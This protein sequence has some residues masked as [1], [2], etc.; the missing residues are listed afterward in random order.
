MR[1]IVAAAV[2][3]DSRIRV[4]DLGC[5]TGALVARLAD[6]LPAATLVGLDVS[7][8]NIAAAER[9]QGDRPSGRIQF[10]A[11]DYVRFE[12]EPFDL[13]VSDGVLHL[14]D[15][16]SGV[17]A[18]KLARDLRLGGTLIC[19][20]PYACA[21]NAVFGIVRRGLRAVRAPWLDRAILQAGRMLH[22]RAMD[23]NGLRERVGYMYMPPRR[24]MGARLERT[25]AAAGLHRQ[26][27]YAMRSTSP[28]QLRHRVTIFARH[29]ATR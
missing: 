24:V 17:L 9:S 21:Y 5:G 2:P 13:I 19:N 7:P 16:D 10:V 23:E 22:G 3:R 27:E 11:G 15:A 28:S 14:I 29:D 8:A 1:D 6:A 4:L 26:A 20:M 25:F 18:A 12:S